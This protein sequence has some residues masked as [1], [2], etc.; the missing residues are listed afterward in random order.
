[1]NHNSQ[2][3]K[4]II[5]RLA[6]LPLVNSV[7]CIFNKNPRIVSV[8]FLVTKTYVSFNQENYQF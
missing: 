4:T 7:C 2:Y 5:N 8:D 3:K 1:M 6:L